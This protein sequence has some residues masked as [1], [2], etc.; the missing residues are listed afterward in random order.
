M[1]VPQSFT[2]TF[3][4]VTIGP[5]TFNYLYCVPDPCHPGQCIMV[6]SYFHPGSGMPGDSCFHEFQALRNLCPEGM[7]CK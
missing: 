7:G 5:F 3:C 1:G 6:R 4:G 2:L